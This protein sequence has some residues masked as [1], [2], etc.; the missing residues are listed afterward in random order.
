MLTIH[1]FWLE[2]KRINDRHFLRHYDDGAQN[3]L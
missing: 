1:D 2:F 3:V